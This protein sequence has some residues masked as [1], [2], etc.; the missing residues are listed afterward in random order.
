MGDAID[1]GRPSS[2][3]TSSNRAKLALSDCL[4]SMHKALK[5]TVCLPYEKK[6]LQRK[7]HLNAHYPFDSK[8]SPTWRWSRSL[9]GVA[10]NRLTPFSK[11]S[12]SPLLL[13]PPITRPKVWLWYFRRSRATPYVCS[14]SSRVGEMIITP[15]PVIRKST[16]TKS[17][18]WTR[19]HHLL[20]YYCH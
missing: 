19:L 12:V 8:L 4:P 18:S 11:R 15:V 14:E 5:T 2:L 13:A 3:S 10:I 6:N 16:E 17:T 7:Q 1:D 20:F 9:P